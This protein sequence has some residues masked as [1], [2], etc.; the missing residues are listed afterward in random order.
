MGSA[1]LPPNQTKLPNMGYAFLPPAKADEVESN[2]LQLRTQHNQQTDHCYSLIQ[3][4]LFKTNSRKSFEDHLWSPHSTFWQILWD[5]DTAASHTC[6]QP[7]A[8][9]PASLSHRQL[10]TGSSF[11][12]QQA[13]ASTAALVSASPASP[14]SRHQHQPSPWATT[15]LGLVPALQGHI[16]I[17]SVNHGLG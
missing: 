16:N 13:P 9:A 6:S 15:L 8:F 5:N 10:Q 4:V 12:K 7:A 14:T 3:T 2:Q 1:S 11:T 17:P